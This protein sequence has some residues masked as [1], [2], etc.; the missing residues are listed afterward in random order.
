MTRPS[1]DQP[2]GDGS[3]SACRLGASL[4]WLLAGREKY[5]DQISSNLAWIAGALGADFIRAFGVLGGDL[6]QGRDPWSDVGASLSW[7]D[8]DARI[9]A[10]TDY[11][12]DTFGLRVMWTLVGSRAQ[13]HHREQ[14]E[15]LVDRFARM[16][17]PRTHKIELV[18]MWNEYRVNGGTSTELRNMARRM[19]DQLPPGFPIALSSPDSVMGESPRSLVLAEIEEL[20]GGDS[21]ANTLTYHPS[22]AQGTVWAPGADLGPHAPALRG[23]T[24]PRGPGASAGGDVSDPATLA[25]DYAQTRDVGWRWYVF[26]TMPGVWGGHCDPAF[27]DQNRWANLFE[28]PHAAAIATALRAVKAGG[29]GGGDT[30]GEDDVKP[31]PD[32]NSWWLDYSKE[33]VALW[34]QAGRH[35]LVALL[36]ADPR[37]LF[38]FSRMGHRSAHN[39]LEAAK[40]KHLDELAAELGVRRR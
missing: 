37:A 38:W 25:A 33:V 10:A 21:G 26:H 12:F 3:G 28:V 16:A 23:N 18:E 36:R 35:D 6:F 15:A 9:A 7:S 13:V 34:E 30:G 2:G 24:E 32:E 22:R 11:V 27:P 17:R 19:R 14:Q 5:P 39:N 40:Q 31:Y 1:T 29:T 8:Y 20:Y 4:F